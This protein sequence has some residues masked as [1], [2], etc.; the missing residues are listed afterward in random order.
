MSQGCINQLREGA[1]GDG[2]SLGGTFS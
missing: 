2:E 1:I